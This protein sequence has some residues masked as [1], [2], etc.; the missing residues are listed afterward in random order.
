MKIHPENNIDGEKE[1]ASIVAVGMELEGQLAKQDGYDGE[2]K[3]EKDVLREKGE[4]II[5]CSM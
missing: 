3:A 5:V 1:F 2:E 4:Q